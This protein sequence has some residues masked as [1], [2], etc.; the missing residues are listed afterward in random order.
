MVRQ[1]R[2]S[3]RYVTPM[4]LMTFMDQVTE[5]EKA[6]FTNKFILP[7]ACSS[8]VITANTSASVDTGTRLSRR[9]ASCI[10]R[11]VGGTW[12]ICS[13][14]FAGVF[15]TSTKALQDTYGYLLYRCNIQQPC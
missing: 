5:S 14:S 12:L 4:Q 7:T 8:L 2:E 10:K 15:T 13:I 3:Y 11:Q 6:N 9:K 1:N